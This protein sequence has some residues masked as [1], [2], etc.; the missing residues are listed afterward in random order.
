MN[1]FRSLGGSS[2]AEDEAKLSARGGQTVIK[3]QAEMWV[4]P[5]N[6]FVSLKEV[7]P[8]QELRRQEKL[9]RWNSS[10]RTV[11]FL[12]HQWTAFDEPDH[13]REQLRTV[14]RLIHRMVSGTC[15]DTAPTFAD[16]AI[17]S[18]SRMRI[19]SNQWQNT[20][21]DAFICAMLVRGESGGWEIPIKHPP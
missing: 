9:V 8:H 18:S 16:A 21:R 10:M 17:F 11:I 4:M 3:M 12:S 20:V 5:V 13:T 14:Q 19:T 1:L 7:R 2:F 15:P 6:V